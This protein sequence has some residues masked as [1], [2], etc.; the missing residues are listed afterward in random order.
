MDEL[1]K[2]KRSI[3]NIKGKTSAPLFVVQVEKVNGAT[4]NVNYDGCSLSDVR[5]RSVINGNA[6]QILITPKVNSYV[7]VTDLSG[8]NL[9]DLA[10]LAYSEI[11]KINIK[12][13]E[14]TVDVNNTGIVFNGGQLDGM[15]QVV[16]MVEWMNKVYTD[17]QKL[18]ALLAVIAVAPN[19]ATGA[20][21]GKAVFTPTTPL[22]ILADF[23]N[24]KV[25]H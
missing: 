8:G 5:L 14:T 1:G 23:K 21:E 11:E 24:D 9:T 19:P 2:I 17:L 10:I 12:I 3:Q 25:K 20:L 7:L 15:V 18:M 13:G 6:E 16:K 4:C 22:P